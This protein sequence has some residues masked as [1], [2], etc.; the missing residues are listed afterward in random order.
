MITTAEEIPEELSRLAGL[1]K[2]AGDRV[3][4]LSLAV[5]EAPARDAVDLYYQACIAHLL[6][7]RDLRVNLGPVA[8]KLGADCAVELQRREVSRG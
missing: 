3:A 5:I 1:A 8:D 4:L 2:A 6:A 7:L